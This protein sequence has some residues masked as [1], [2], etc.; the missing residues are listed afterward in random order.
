M[1]STSVSSLPSR[2]RCADTSRR[3]RRISKLLRRARRDDVLPMSCTSPF[4]VGAGFFRR[5]FLR[6]PRPC[7]LDI[8]Q[9]DRATAAFITP[10]PTSPPAQEHLS[11]AEQV[12]DLVHARISVLPITSSARWNGRA[13]PDAE[14]MKS[15]TPL[16]RAY[17]S[18]A[19]TL[20]SRQAASSRES[21]PPCRD[22]ARRA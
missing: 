14:S 16:T 8:G 18:R 10:R 3:D 22:I 20:A 17:S 6:R 15:V 19:S 2:M 7:R 4:T 1:M 21:L 9:A 11:G 12:A 13:P 5:S